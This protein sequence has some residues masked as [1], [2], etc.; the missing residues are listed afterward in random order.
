M[1]ELALR[2]FFHEKGYSA[3]WIEHIGIDRFHSCVEYLVVAPY[4]M[5]RKKL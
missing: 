5:K 1:V 4:K 3:P 2:G